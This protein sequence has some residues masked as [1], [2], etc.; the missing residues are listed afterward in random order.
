MKLSMENKTRQILAWYV[1]EMLFVQ[2]DFC[3]IV[4]PEFTF[5]ME[6]AVLESM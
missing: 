1:K 4:N 5:Q 6:S 3:T 2:K